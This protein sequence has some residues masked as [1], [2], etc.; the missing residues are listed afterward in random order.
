MGGDGQGS[1]GAAI[2][3]PS[4]GARFVRW[5]NNVHRHSGVG[6]VTPSQRY[7][8]QD[9]ALLAARHELHSDDRP[10]HADL[11][12]Y[13]I[14]SESMEVSAHFA[15]FLRQGEPDP[16]PGGFSGDDGAVGLSDIMTPVQLS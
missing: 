14:D 1:D 8:G 5:Y 6:Y 10:Q 4:E 15:G 2:G 3:M 13:Q 7:T 12:W 16:P 9:R 11:C